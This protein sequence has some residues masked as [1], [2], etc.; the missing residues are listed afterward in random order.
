[1]AIS[2]TIKGSL[3][4]YITHPY[5][6]NL[7]KIKISGNPEYTSPLLV[8]KEV[9]EK[10]FDSLSGRDNGHQINCIYYSS[11]EGKFVEKWISSNLVHDIEYLAFNNNFLTT[12]N[13]K[14]EIQPKFTNISFKNYENHIKDFYVNRKVILRSVDIE[15]EKIKVNRTKENGDLVETNHLEFLPPVMTIL[16]YRWIDE[17]NKFCSK[18]GLPLIELKCNWYNSKLKTF[19]ELHFPYEVL[20]VINEPTEFFGKDLLQEI[21]E[22]LDKNLVFSLKLEKSFSLESEDPSKANVIICNS[23]G[24]SQSMIFK[25]Y[26]YLM[27]YYDLV[28]QKKNAIKI[29]SVFNSLNESAFFG[30]K[31]PSYINGRNSSVNDC[32]FK[33]DD[34]FLIQYTDAY[35]NFTK[36]IIKALETFI[37]I[38]NVEDF[39]IEYPT[40]QLDEDGNDYAFIKYTKSQQGV[41]IITDDGNNSMIQ[42]LPRSIFKDDNLEFIIKANCL[43]RKGLIRNFKLKH[44]KQVQ[45]ILEGSKRFECDNAASKVPEINVSLSQ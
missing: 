41:D 7:T 17:K 27:S 32:E 28:E 1:M 35:G 6:G 2:Q 12:I 25:H 9:K 16:G 14:D 40:F 10:S 33:K 30:Q 38:K 37:Y 44:I 15:L 23:I 4:A 22:S 26:Y 13:F 42:N 18:T 8:V 19:S 31:F 11:S 24:T 39:R 45:V 43:L 36:R 3:V 20:Y 34:Y 21:S 5:R 29:D